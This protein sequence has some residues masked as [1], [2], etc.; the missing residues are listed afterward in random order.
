[1]DTYFDSCLMKRIPKIMNQDIGCTVPYLPDNEYPVCNPD[2]ISEAYQLYDHLLS[3]MQRLLCQKPCS[4]MTVFV[5]FPFPESRID[6]L[7]KTIMNLKST[8]RVK[9]TVLNYGSLSML[10]EIGG[11]SGLL[12]G[13][14][15][16]NVNGIVHFMAKKIKKKMNE[17]KSL[18]KNSK[19]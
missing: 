14:S 9:K 6:G 17:I 10:A 11:Y 8:T 1:M 7:A 15:L 16:V 19:K 2:L 4:F 12:L 13:V 18:N 5:G 3:G